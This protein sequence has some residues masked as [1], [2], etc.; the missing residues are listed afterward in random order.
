VR[1]GKDYGYD[2]LAALAEQAPPFGPVVDPDHPLFLPHGDMPPRIFHYCRAT[3]QEPPV[4]PGEVVRCALESLA[5]KYRLV[6]EEAER[7]AGRQAR[8]IHVVGGGSRNA[9]LNQLTADATGRPVLAGPAEATAIGNLLVQALALGRLGSPRQIREVVRRS[10]DLVRYEPRG[11]Q[12][13]WDDAFARLVRLI[14][15]PPSL[16]AVATTEGR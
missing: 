15:A 6:I 5:L 10:F 8:L 11:D 2:D 7:L 9:L 13:R 3:G 16:E 14:A 4:T 12:A 1:G